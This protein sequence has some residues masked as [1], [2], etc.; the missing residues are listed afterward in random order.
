MITIEGTVRNSAGDPIAEISVV[1][2]DESYATHAEMSTKT[3]GTFVFSTERAGTY[4]LRTERAG[5]PV[6]PRPNWWCVRAKPRSISIWLSSLRDAK[7]SLH[8]HRLEPSSFKTGLISPWLGLPTGATSACTARTAVLANQRNTR[9]RDSRTEIKWIGRK[10]AWSFCG[11]GD[12]PRKT[13]VRKQS[14][15]SPG[16]SPEQLPSQSSARR[17]LL[18]FSN[19]SRRDSSARSCVSDQS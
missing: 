6:A 5:V 10:F 11:C 12:R 14:A 7:L 15:R 1:L 16:S 17:I 2:E 9:H 18:S 8:T 3:D 13:R 4:K 19:I